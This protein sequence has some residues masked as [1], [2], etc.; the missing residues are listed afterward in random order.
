MLMVISK[1]ILSLKAG[2][3]ESQL[4]IALEPEAASIFCRHLPQTRFRQGDYVDLATFQEGTQYMLLVAGGMDIQKT[5]HV[6]RR[7]IVQA[8]TV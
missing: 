2:I 8:W 5:G 4:M 7:T 1:A 3:P 6:P